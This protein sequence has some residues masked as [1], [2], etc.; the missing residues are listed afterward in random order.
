MVLFAEF[1]DWYSVA[2]STG[3]P[4]GFRIFGIYFGVTV[5]SAAALGNTIWNLLSLGV[6]YYGTIALSFIGVKYDR[7]H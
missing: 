3:H 2:P 4:F 1:I 7:A 6:V 5:M